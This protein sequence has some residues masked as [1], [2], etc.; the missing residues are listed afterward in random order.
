[1]SGAERGAFF[2]QAERLYGQSLLFAFLD[3][4]APKANSEFAR[5][6]PVE[7]L[8]PVAEYSDIRLAEKPLDEFGAY[9][10]IVIEKPDCAAAGSGSPYIPRF[11]LSSSLGIEEIPK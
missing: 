1:M 10:R 2:H 5:G 6:Q 7:P 9:L 4:F 8:A 3:S 11:D